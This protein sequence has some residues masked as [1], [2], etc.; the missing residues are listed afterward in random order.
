[1]EVVVSEVI[2]YKHLLE[3]VD[4]KPLGLTMLLNLVDTLFIIV[5]DVTIVTLSCSSCS[6]NIV[7]RN[8][9]CYTES[10]S[11]RRSSQKS[12]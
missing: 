2:N 3:S 10:R 4:G 9:S 6:F 5:D 8:F 7:C 1:M 11:L 12:W